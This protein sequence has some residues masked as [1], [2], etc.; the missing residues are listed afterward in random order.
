MYDK[1]P[2]MWRGIGEVMCR[3][4]DLTNMMMGREMPR[5]NHRGLDPIYKLATEVRRPQM[6]GKG[7]TPV[8]PCR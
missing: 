5:V 2:R 3:H 6:A 8:D 4:D 7:Y 1:Y